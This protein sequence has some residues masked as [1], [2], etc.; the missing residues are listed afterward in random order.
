MLGGGKLGSAR[1]PLRA[2]AAL[3]VCAPTASAASIAEHGVLADPAAGLAAGPD[4]AL[5]HTSSGK[6]P[7]VGRTTL[8]GLTRELP[9]PGSAAV[10]EIVRGPDNALWFT[11][12]DGG[13]GRVTL[14]GALDTVATLGDAATA[15]AAGADG[16]VWATVPGK[17]KKDSGAIARITPAGQ[18]T[19]FTG[20]S[21]DPQDIA[22]G[23][24][25]ALWFTEPDADR[26]GRITPG[27]QISEFGV[28]SQPT[29]LTAAFDGAV[30][31]TA[32]H[33]IG[34]IALDG[35]VS[36]VKVRNPQPGA[37]ALGPDGALWFARGNG[38]GRV[39]TLG[40][41]SEVS[42]PSQR[43]TALTAGA[44]GA[45]WF[46]D[47]RHAT[48]GRIDVA[49]ATALAAP[50][51]GETVVT[52]VKRGKVK[53][54]ARGSERFVELTGA[55]SLPVGSVVD[56]SRGRVAVQSVDAAGTPQTGTFYG[57]R[58]QIR[59]PRAA[60][61]LVKIALRGRL[62]CAR[63][64]RLAVISRKRRRKRRKVWG[65]DSGGLFATL[66]LDSITTVRGTKWLTEDR[67]R[68]TLTRVVRGSVMVRERRTGKRFVLHAGERH[69]AR[70][71]R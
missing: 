64:G 57:G 46:A 14:A 20:L 3:L 50:E 61:G 54:K 39:T 9:L 47:A 37:I 36:S 48:L 33:A 70:H 24:D 43:P 6:T 69:F 29:A 35:T 22:I 25:G 23:W 27:G 16:N 59:Q 8:A 15:L 1:T 26:I 58:F 51:L 53:V 30:W 5:W 40:V 34:R 60:D 18:V 2:L 68:G 41:V 28:A 11:R 4:G 21:G 63:P 62:D 13:I 42:T 10:G 55:A 32:K 67:C 66:G 52:K 31:F 7:R 12:A 49:D 56:A 19:E 45:L 17:G 71:R 44:D 65:S 38:I